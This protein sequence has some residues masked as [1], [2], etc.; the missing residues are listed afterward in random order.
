MSRIWCCI[1]SYIMHP[2]YIFF[3]WKIDLKII[4]NISMGVAYSFKAKHNLHCSRLRIKSIQCYCTYIFSVNLLCSLKIKGIGHCFRVTLVRHSSQMS[5]GFCRVPLVLE[6]DFVRFLTFFVKFDFWQFLSSTTCTRAQFL[7][8]F[9]TIFV[10]FFFHVFC[11]E[12]LELFFFYV[13]CQVLLLRF[14]SNTTRARI[15]TSDT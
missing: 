8:F 6:L 3:V 12:A 5:Y 11:R 9:V 4:R 15:F 1:S 7:T 10:L 2:K 14:L 13:F